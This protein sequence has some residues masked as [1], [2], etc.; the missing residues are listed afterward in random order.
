MYESSENSGWAKDY[1][2]ILKMAKYIKHHMKKL[3]IGN[4]YRFVKIS[5][6]ILKF[7]KAKITIFDKELCTLAQDM[8]MVS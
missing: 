1:I 5:R 6:I 7:K 8:K 4:A 2:S 3:Y